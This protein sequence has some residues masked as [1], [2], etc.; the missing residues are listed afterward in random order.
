MSTRMLFFGIA[1]A[2]LV[3]IGASGSA[4]D[5]YSALDRLKSRDIKVILEFK[6]IPL[7]QILKVIAQAGSFELT[8]GESFSDSKTSI[9]NQ[10]T[11]IRSVLVQLARE[12]AL[13]YTVPGPEELVVE[14]EHEPEPYRDGPSHDGHE[15]RPR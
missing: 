12:N 11:T 14:S 5:E 6:D 15:D 1:I 2:I 3:S 4:S 9:P 10:E 7:S 8:L 13:L